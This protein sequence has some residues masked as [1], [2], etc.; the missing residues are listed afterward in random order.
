M[1]PRAKYEDLL[2]MSYKDLP[3][4]LPYAARPRY[5]CRWCREVHNTPQQYKQAMQGILGSRDAMMRIIS[6]LLEP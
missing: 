1:I 3:V 5:Y 4:E 2:R 6:L